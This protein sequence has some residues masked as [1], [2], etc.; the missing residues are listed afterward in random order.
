MKLKRFV[1][2]LSLLVINIG[3]A[4]S[5]SVKQM[6]FLTHQWEGERFDDGRPKVAADIL[7]RMKKVTIE[8]AWG[9]LRNE[10]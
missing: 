10:G 4:Q 6:K 1:L 9:V 2:F 8:E 7:E 5:L 3:F